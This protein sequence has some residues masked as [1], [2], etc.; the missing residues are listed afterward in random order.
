MPRGVYNRATMKP[1]GRQPVPVIYSFAKHI[2]EKLMVVDISVD[3]R[4]FHLTINGK[5]TYH[6]N[7]G[8]LLKSLAEK[9]F[10]SLPE[11][12]ENLGEFYSDVMNM[13][14]ET[15]NVLNTQYAKFF[16]MKENPRDYPNSKNCANEED[17][18]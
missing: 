13:I 18:D 3:T 7:P 8:A 11:E 9:G 16:E 10:R 12:L 17:E 15:A 1:R 4:C 14:K 6:D 5:T 2:A